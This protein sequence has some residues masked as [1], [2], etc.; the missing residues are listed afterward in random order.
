MD[1]GS[2]RHTMTTTSA[3]G[4]D[5]ESVIPAGRRLRS[6]PIGWRLQRLSPC[7][8]ESRL[9]RTSPPGVPLSKEHRTAKNRPVRR[10]PPLFADGY[11]GVCVAYAP[12]CRLVRA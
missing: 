2:A 9:V 6:C 8:V 12:G 4:C 3:F 10:I 1:D 7:V 11:T 5:V